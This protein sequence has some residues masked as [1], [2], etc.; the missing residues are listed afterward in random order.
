MKGM[1]DYTFRYI[2]KQAIIY[3]LILGGFLEIMNILDY[4]V[5][6]YEQSQ[7]TNNIKYL[8]RIFGLLTCVIIFRRKIGGYISFEVAFM[9]CLFTF[10]FAMFAYDTMICIT[11][12]IYPELLLNKIEVIKEALQKAGVSSRLVELSA[13]HALWEKNPYYVIF[14]FIVWV[15]FVGPL[16]SF[17]FALMMQKNKVSG[18]NT[19]PFS[20]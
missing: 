5:G 17:I 4:T 18:E 8:F 15:L 13:N 12:N 16:L 2:F 19:Q 3:G 7:I 11:F 9:F 10:V 6:F 14:S 1:T 20:F